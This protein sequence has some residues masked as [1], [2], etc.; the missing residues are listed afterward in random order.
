MIQGKNFVT[1]QGWMR[2]ELN[3]K[4]NELIVYAVIYGF[5][6]T[7]EQRF[8]GSLQYL[9]DWCAATKQGV[10]KN[11]KSLTDK[12]LIERHERFVN[13][14]KFVEY[15]S[16]QFNGV[17]NSVSQG[18]KL[19]LPNNKEDIIDHKKESIG[20]P[21]KEFTDNEELRNALNEFVKMRKVIKK[22]LTQYALERNLKKLKSLSSDIQEQIMIVNQSVEHSWQGFFEVKDKRPVYNGDLDGIL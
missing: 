2:T 10:L 7:E 1:I 8:T 13:G 19:S 16:T 4:G 11:L 18:I 6:Q 21:I 15:R 5:S 12:G 9:A 20:D 14:V 22:P 3:L 17:L